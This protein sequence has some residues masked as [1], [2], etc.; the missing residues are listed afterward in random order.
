MPRAGWLACGALAAALSGVFAAGADLGVQWLATVALVLA[1]GASLVLFAARRRFRAALFAV[2]LLTVSLR[3]LVG[4]ALAPGVPSPGPIPTGVGAWGAEVVRLG[5][6]DGAMQRAL[7]LVT[8]RGS[9]ASDGAATAVGPWPI[10]A[11]LPRYPILSSGDHLAFEGRLD[12]L[13]EGPGFGDALRTQGAVASIRLRSVELLP[14]E[15]GWLS[16]IEPIRRAAGDRLLASLPQREAGLASGI[17]VGLRELVDRDVAA[18]FTTAGLS[19]VVAI[20]GWNIAQVG[21]VIVSLLRW[22]PRR[23]R[24]LLVILAIVVYTLLAGGSA[25]VVRAA[26][27]GAVALLARESGRRGGAATALGVAVWLLLLADPPMA[28]DVGFQLSS[29]ATA[30]LLAWATPLQRRLRERAWKRLPEWLIETM[31]VSLAAQ[32]ATLPLVLLHFGRLSLVSPLANLVA[33]PLIAPVMLLCLVALIC[34]VFI[35]AGAPALVLA[36]GLLPA[37]LGLA[38]LIGIADVSAALPFASVTLPPPLDVAGA[39]IAA[40]GVLI[41]GTP[42][43]R[44][45]WTRLLARV[46]RAR[47]MPAGS[48]ARTQVRSPGGRSTRAAP[49]EPSRTATGASAAAASN[50]QAMGARRALKVAAILTGTLLLASAAVVAA[51]PDG[52]LRITVLDVGQ[53]DAILIEGSR[54]TRVLIDGGPDPDVLLRRLDERIATW[55]RRL[56]LVVLSHPHEDHVGG[57]PVLLSRYPVEAV[58]ETGM[59]GNGPADHALRS[60]LAARG[61]ETIR[62][63]ATDRLDLDGADAQ[64]L[65]PRAGEVPLHPQNNGSAVNDVSIVLDIRFGERRFLLTGDVEQEIDPELLAAGLGS[66]DQPPVDLLKVAHHGSRT[67]TTDALLR[68]IAPKVAFVSAGL[69]NPYG[70]PAPSTMQRLQAAGAD[71]YRTD[72]DGDLVAS[73]DGTDLLVST[74]GPRTAP[75]TPRATT[76]SALAFSC[77]IA[78]S[79]VALASGQ[80]EAAHEVLRLPGAN[81]PAAP[82]RHARLRLHA[83]KHLSL[84]RHLPRPTDPVPEMPCYD[85]P[86]DRPL[87]RRS[88]S[89]A[90]RAQTRSQAPPPHDRGRGNCRV[91]GR[92]RRRARPPD[93]QAAGRDRGPPARSGQGPAR[94]RP[95]QGPGPRH[96]RRQVAHGPRLCHARAA[97]RVAPRDSPE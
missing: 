3:L 74:S 83:R 27:M 94:G 61:I 20:S 24:S 85:R 97:G 1:G 44:T 86:D 67:A 69:G 62:L 51:R 89:A 60:E 90:A 40:A 30:C 73:S 72:R 34:G 37:W 80:P 79:V 36:P 52:R 92:A 28:S 75:P 81:A 32:A 41:W 10:Y 39:A 26:V 66:S 9:P 23:S 93:R 46:R 87:A 43:G 19:H 48:S 14:P 71:V 6:T 50:E 13:P 77:A 5:S 78:R 68:A 64:V 42:T 76:T 2:G 88:R 18:S 38:A 53:G 84:H 29:A 82:R 54:G 33:A 21:A 57:L 91:P 56:D 17:L 16:A 4:L 22:M 47:G 45:C 31:A 49:V 70:H 65:W 95:A 63:A 96:G 12:P 25:S 11:W 35:G 8:P 15:S 58:A 7:L 55:D 59:L